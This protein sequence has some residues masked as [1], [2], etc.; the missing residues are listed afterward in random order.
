MGSDV[1]FSFFKN[2]YSD[3]YDVIDYKD[4]MFGLGRRN[5][6]IKFYYLFRHY[7]L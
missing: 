5:N 7:G 6:S 2:H 3:Q 1:S 4:W